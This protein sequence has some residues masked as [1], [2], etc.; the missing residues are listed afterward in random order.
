[1]TVTSA[2]LRYQFLIQW[3]EV[4]HRNAE[5][6]DKEERNTTRGTNSSE[7]EGEVL[8]KHVVEE[9]NKWQGLREEIA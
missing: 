3:K 1:M 7:Q 4:R 8:L 6:R 9:V 5:A 2:A